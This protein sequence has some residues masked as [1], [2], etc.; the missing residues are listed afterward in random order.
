[1]ILSPPATATE[2]YSSET[3]SSLQKSSKRRASGIFEKSS[4]CRQRLEAVRAMLFKIGWRS[5]CAVSQLYGVFYLYDDR[6]DDF[7]FL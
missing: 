7:L 3:V 2:F 1:M 5:F 4:I 6:R